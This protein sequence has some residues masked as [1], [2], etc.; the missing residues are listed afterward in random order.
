[1]QKRF[2]LLVALLLSGALAFAQLTPHE[3][4]AAMGRGIN[5]G[6][7]LE[8]PTEGAWNNGPAQEAYFDAYVAAGFTNVRIPV[9]WDQHTQTGAPYTVSESWMNRVEQ[10]VDWGLDRG[11]YV[12]LNGHHEDWLKEN[13]SQNNQNRYDAIWRQIIERFQG[14]SDKLLY[15]IINE[16]R[17]LTRGQVDEL[18][19]RILGIIRA[20][21]P[22]RLVIFGG[23]EYS[24]ADELIAAAVPG[25][26]DPYL[27]GYY[28]SY[29]PWPFAGEGQGTWGS[30][31]DYN[32]ANAKFQRVANWSAQ[33]NIPVHLSEFNTRVIS[34][35]NS[36][37]RW[38]ANYVEQSI[39]HGFAFSVWDDGGW[40]KVLNRGNNTWPPIKDVFVHYYPESMNE[41][42]SANEP[43]DENTPA[44][45]VTWNNRA[46]DHGEIVVERFR[47][48]TGTFSEVARLPADATAYYD[49]DV[50][51]GNLYTYRMYTVA[52]DGTL[53]HGYATRLSVNTSTAAGQGAYEGTPMSIPGTLEVERYDTG[54]E[55]EAYSDNEPANLGGGF[56]TDEGVDIGADATGFVLGYVV[57]G[58]WLEYTVDVTETGTYSLAASVASNDAA[59][60][61]SVTAGDRVIDFD[62]PMTNGWSNYRTIDAS[63]EDVF[64]EA[65][66]QII[67]IDIS[68][69]RAFNVDYLTFTLE[70]SNTEEQSRAA[71]FAVSPNPARAEVS[72]TLPAAF[73]S[74]T[75]SVINAAGATVRTYAL[76]A[77]THLLPIGELKAG[78]YVLRFGN[79]RDRL[80][81][82][83]LV[84]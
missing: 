16:P 82:R 70:S 80:V 56:R 9:R 26:D 58:E 24:N 66:Q 36:R 48:E 53:R 21:E 30:P 75:L 49:T 44:V 1:M 15:E 3:A 35:Y 76:D 79:G 45:R 12:T 29:D 60:R 46:S 52:D 11:L 64:L 2:P 34:D 81:R 43:I 20:E 37:M 19:E 28:H 57:S 27:I 78:L 47:G 17:G 6:N 10:V 68:G 32:A 50:F 8:P 73:G 40:F 5:L 71:G 42:L 61:F 23:N 54:G 65:G 13:Y 25:D 67:R 69:S 14:K 4:V 33:R 62:T 38:L 83:L 72:V 63:G 41:I 74:G 55:G 77:G 22:T 39:V 31:A 59:S 18:N 84:E 7:T 51:N